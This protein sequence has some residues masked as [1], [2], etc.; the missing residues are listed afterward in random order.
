MIRESDG[1]IQDWTKNDETMPSN[2]RKLTSLCCW[3]FQLLQHRHHRHLHH[4]CGFGAHD[5]GAAGLG[6]ELVVQVAHCLSQAVDLS[7]VSTV[8]LGRVPQRSLGDGVGV[9]LGDQ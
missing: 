3:Q 4:H 9:S 1:N 5:A 8:V 2:I 6:L 7:Q